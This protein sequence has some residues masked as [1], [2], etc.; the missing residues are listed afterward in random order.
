MANED[1]QQL[2]VD[3][4]KNRRQ[5]ISVTAQKQQLQMQT[6]GVNASIE[7]LEKTKEKKV[8]KAVGNI[9][10]LSDAS[11]VKGE[12]KEQKESL[13]LRIKALQKQEDTVLDKLNKLKAKIESMQKGSATGSEDA[14]N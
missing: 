8:Y 14:Q 2:A 5:L 1:F 7:E 4:D 9:L 12:L 13:E 3:F 11:K 6:S 10:V